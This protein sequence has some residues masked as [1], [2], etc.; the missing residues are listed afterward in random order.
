MQQSKRKQ[1]GT[2]N[3]PQ[4]PANQIYAACQQSQYHQTKTKRIKST[5]TK[6][7]Q[8]TQT[9][10]SKAETSNPSTNKLST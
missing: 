9:N 6:V 3:N 10:Q 7:K 1:I 5:A 8:T 4:T 2:N